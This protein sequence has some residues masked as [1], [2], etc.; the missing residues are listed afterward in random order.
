[1]NSPRL[2]ASLALAGLALA[3]APAA[4]DVLVRHCDT[5][6]TTGCSVASIWVKPASAINVQVNRAGSPF[7]RLADV[8]PSERIAA[9]YNDPAIAAGSSAKCAVS[10]P[11]R[12]DQWELKSVLFPTGQVLGQITLTWD[13]VTLDTEGQPFTGTTGYI[14]NR[15]QDVCL[16]TSTDPRCG[17]MPWIT[18]DVGNVTRKVF[19]GL[20]GR[21]CFTVQGYI[22]S[23]EFGAMPATPGCA[24]AGQKLRLSGTVQN[25]KATG[26]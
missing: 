22:V 12:T 4:A 14:V 3:C 25:V 5:P 8:Q 9:C 10:V 26:P 23:R 6:A 2:L 24:V 17:T 7:V 11:N 13:A 19:E 15:Q 21:W 16:E 1:M 18:E 20:A